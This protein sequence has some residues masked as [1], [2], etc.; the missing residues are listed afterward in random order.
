MRVYNLTKEDIE[1][2][3]S[4]IQG[5]LFILDTFVHALIDIG[6][7]H[8]FISHALVGNLRVETEFMGCLMVISTPMGKSMK[9]SKMVREC[10]VSLSNVRFQSNLILLEVYDFDVT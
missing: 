5:A 4:V 8:F 6:S 9:S 2:N 10:E 7:N 1:V 3:P